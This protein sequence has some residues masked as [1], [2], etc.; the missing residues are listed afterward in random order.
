MWAVGCVLVI[1]VRDGSCGR[2]VNSGVDDKLLVGSTAVFFCL[3]WLSFVLATACQRFS[4]AGWLVFVQLLVFLYFALLNHVYFVVGFSLFSFSLSLSLSPDLFM[5][6]I[7]ELG[8][9]LPLQGFVYLYNG[10]SFERPETFRVFKIDTKGRPLPMI[11]SGVIPKGKFFVSSGAVR[12]YDS[13]YW[14][15]IDE[16]E[17]IGRAYPIL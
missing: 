15:L 10:K 13:R 14:G 4:V 9:E 7:E 3:I 2:L 8:R 12:S 17:G 11:E 5:C 6:Y 16:S 1:V